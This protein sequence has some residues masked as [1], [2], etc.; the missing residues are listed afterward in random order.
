MQ[1]ISK[2]RPKRVRLEEIYCILYNMILIISSNQLIIMYIVQ[3]RS[4]LE[5]SGK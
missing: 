3:Y 2:K 5:W 1:D 4:Q